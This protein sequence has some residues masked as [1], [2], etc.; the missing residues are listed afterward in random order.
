[1]IRLGLSESTCSAEPAS[2]PGSLSCSSGAG[3]FNLCS[4]GEEDRLL[5]GCSFHFS[6]EKENSLRHTQLHLGVSVSVCFS[7]SPTETAEINIDSIHMRQTGW[8]KW[9]VAGVGPSLASSSERGDDIVRILKSELQIRW[10]DEGISSLF[11]PCCTCSSE[12]QRSPV[13]VSSCRGKRHTSDLDAISGSSTRHPGWPHLTLS[14][15]KIHGW[16]NIIII[17]IIIII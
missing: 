13:Q 7:L 1:M 3:F 10:Q 17:T 5:R 8:N 4:S 2:S 16:L 14:W 9:D 6:M 15:L 12:C 11:S